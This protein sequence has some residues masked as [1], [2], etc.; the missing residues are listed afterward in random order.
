LHHC[1]GGYVSIVFI[2]LT[3][4]STTCLHDKI[5]TTSNILSVNFVEDNFDV[6]YEGPLITYVS[7][8][9]TFDSDTTYL[10][11]AQISEINIILD[12]L[13]VSVT[14]IK[15][16]TLNLTGLLYGNQMNSLGE[17]ITS[18]QTISANLT[19]IKVSSMSG[20]PATNDS[21]ASATLAILRSL[22]LLLQ[23]LGMKCE[24]L[25]QM[26]KT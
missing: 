2:C 24:F 15:L 14:T 20:S 18:L 11:A 16:Q 9:I 25:L 19:A 7:Q 6:I 1:C 10:E 13:A 21:N 22:N 12:Y 8:I 5:H 26:L 17:V 3:C 4:H 23:S